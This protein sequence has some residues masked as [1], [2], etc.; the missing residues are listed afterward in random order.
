M[1]FDNNIRRQNHSIVCSECASAGDQ[2]ALC[3]HYEKLPIVPVLYDY[4]HL[5][6]DPARHDDCVS[7]AVPF[8]E[9]LTEE[10]RIFLQFGLRIGL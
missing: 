10:D 3:T 1:Q 2:S 6:G 4:S 5:V 7:A 8:E 9:L